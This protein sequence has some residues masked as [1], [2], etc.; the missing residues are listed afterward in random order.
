MNV[1]GIDAKYAFVGNPDQCP[2]TC[3][4]QTISPNNN[5]GADAMASSIAQ[6]LDELVTDPLGTAWYD[7]QGRENATKCDGQYGTTFI[8]GNGSQYNIV[9]N[10][11]RSCW[12]MAMALS[13]YPRT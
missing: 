3:E 13:A 7:D 8:A 4:P 12:A 9:L 2:A 10:G 1:N 6:F 5:P 11:M